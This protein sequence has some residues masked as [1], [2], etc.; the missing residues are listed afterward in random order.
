MHYVAEH[1]PEA[2]ATK[3]AH[4]SVARRVMAPAA[5]MP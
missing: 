3:T 1:A 5:V 4:A 2:S